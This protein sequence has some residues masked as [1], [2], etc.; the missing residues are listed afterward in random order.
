MPKGRNSVDGYSRDRSTASGPGT[1]NFQLDYSDYDR[2][3]RRAMQSMN[4]LEKTLAQIEAFINKNGGKSEF[5][6][7]RIMKGDLTAFAKQ[8]ARRTLPAGTVQMQVEAKKAMTPFADEA[9]DIMKSFVNRIDTGTMNREVR[10]RID[11]QGE[12]KRLNIRVG[13]VRLW[14]KYFD[15]QEYGT[16][17]IPPMKALFNTR[18][19]AESLFNK[20]VNRFY[21]SYL[22][23]GGKANY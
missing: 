20:S 12:I 13:W 22:L 6:N 3:L 1:L 23:K 5:G 18:L 16:Q 10:Y 8:I 11:P 9:K 7:V 15:Y 4:E 19:R 17:Y 21:R 2:G 14:Y